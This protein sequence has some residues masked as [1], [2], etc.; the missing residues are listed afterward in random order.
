MKKQL[1][2]LLGA[3]AAAG[4]ATYGIANLI[5]DVL[6]KRNIELPDW[7][8]EKFTENSSN[9]PREYRIAALKWVENYGYEKLEMMS[10]D[11]LR[12]RGYLLRPEKE[13]DVYVF[14][15]HGYRSD[16]KGEWAR[17]AKFYVEDMGFNMLFV[18]HRASGESEGEIIGFDSFEH[19]DCLKWL[20]FMND[21]FGKDIQIILHGIS[22]GS[23]TVLMMSGSEKLPE[24]VRFTVSDC[25]Y[26]SALNEFK[27]KMDSLGIPTGPLF[28][29]IAGINV[30]KAG[31]DFH[32]DTNA[33]DAVKRAKLPILFIHGAEDKFVPTFMVHE[34]YEA[35]TG[36]YKDLLIVEKAQHAESYYFGKEAYEKKII[37]F[38]KKFIR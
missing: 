26:T 37:E 35:Y 18:D 11:G 28:P 2:I 4:A 13:S 1:A 16:G 38:V 32:K 31:Y 8:L 19:K 36:E 7:F 20:G 29:V 17:Y 9:I 3:A 25:G 34:L 22:M 33:F 21:T 5:T 6:V 30:K 10:D 15:A 24:N 23:A 12:L 14:C 27:S